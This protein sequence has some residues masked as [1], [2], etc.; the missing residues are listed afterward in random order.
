M[1][2]PSHTKLTQINEEL[3]HRLTSCYINFYLF[4]YTNHIREGGFEPKISDVRINTLNH[5]SYKP[6]IAYF[7]II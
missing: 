7:S 1:G 4:I 2:S 5:L 6:L 3:E